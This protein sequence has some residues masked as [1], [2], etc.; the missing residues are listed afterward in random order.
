MVMTCMSFSS[1]NRLSVMMQLCACVIS[2]SESYPIWIWMAGPAIQ[3]K[4]G[5]LFC[6]FFPI[7]SPIFGLNLACSWL[8]QQLLFQVGHPSLKLDSKHPN[9]K[10]VIKMYTTMEKY[11]WIWTRQGHPDSTKILFFSMMSKTAKPG[12]R[13][14]VHLRSWTFTY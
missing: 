14:Y 2:K 11:I 7:S 4:L 9:L 12:W 1:S 8:Y 10:M 6:E 3:F 13:T 5:W